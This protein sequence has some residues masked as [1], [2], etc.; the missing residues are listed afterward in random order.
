MQY[1]LLTRCMRIKSQFYYNLTTAENVSIL[2]NYHFKHKNLS[3]YL[4]VLVIGEYLRILLDNKLYLNNLQ[5][6]Q[7]N[8]SNIVLYDLIIYYGFLCILADYW[9]EILT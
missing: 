6:Q 7:L 2:I 1:M 4:W 8:D 3:Q 9:S 5:H